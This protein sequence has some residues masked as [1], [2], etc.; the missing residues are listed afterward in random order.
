MCGRRA[1]KA[2]LVT[3]L[4]AECTGF[5]RLSMENK[6]TCFGV[7][8]SKFTIPYVLALLWA[9]LFS[10][11]QGLAPCRLQPPCGLPLLREVL[12]VPGGC[13]GLRLRVQG[14]RMAGPG[15]GGLLSVD[16]FFVVFS[17]GESLQAPQVV[18]FAPTLRS[19]CPQ[20][21]FCCFCLFLKADI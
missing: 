18:G 17:V 9:V 1:W 14:V 3:L 15:R 16:V 2:W 5:L 12:V 13:Q 21:H 10:F 4:C 20:N 19:G 8:S 7:A 11:P 6:I